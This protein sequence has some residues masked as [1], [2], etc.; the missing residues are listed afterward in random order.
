MH[1]KVLHTFNLDERC[2]VLNWIAA[3]THAKLQAIMIKDVEFFTRSIIFVV[4]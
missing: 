4:N 2:D 3:P 1:R